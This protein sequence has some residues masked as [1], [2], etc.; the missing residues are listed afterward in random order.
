M[1]GPPGNAARA[2]IEG[3]RNGTITPRQGNAGIGSRTKVDVTMGLFQGVSEKKAGRPAET[4]H[5]TR[6][7]EVL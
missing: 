5:W 4:A 7:V 1:S 3:V 2:T 6:E